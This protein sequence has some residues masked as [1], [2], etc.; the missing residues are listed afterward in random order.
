MNVEAR[1]LGAALLAAGLLGC[2]AAGPPRMAP[3]PPLTADEQLRVVPMMEVEDRR[4]VGL[5]AALEAAAAASPA[6]RARAAL[7]VGRLRAADGR[8]VLLRLL[9]DPDTAVAATAAFALG[10]LGDSATAPHLAHALESAGPA[11]RTVAAEAAYALGKVRSADA[12]SALESF[13]RSGDPAAPG[14][15]EPV[16]SALLATWR[17]PRPADV[18]FIIRWTGA[19]DPGLRWRAAYALVRR[20]TPAAA[21]HMQ[22]LASDPDPRV[23]AMA[24]RGVTRAMADSAGI[25]TAALPLIVAAVNDADYAVRVNAVRTLGTYPQSQSVEL[26][27]ALVAGEDRHLAVTA[28]ESLGRLGAAAAAS[29][30]ALAA[31]VADASRPVFVRQTALESLARIAPARA[32]EVATRHAA[33]GEWR[34]RVGAA[35]A[36]A[37]TGG[38]DRAGA[39]ARDPDG[40]VAAAALTALV[41]AAGESLAPLRPLLIEALSS[42]DI[43]VRTA[44]IGALGRMADPADLPLLLDAYDRALR[45]DDNDAQLAAID[46]LARLQRPG[47]APGRAFFARFPRPADPLVRLRASERFPEAGAPWGDPLPIDPRPVPYA[48]LLALAHTPAGGQTLLIETDQGTI[49]LRMA[50]A[51]APL[52]VHNFVELARAGYFDGQ[53]WPRVVP[54]FVVQ[55]GDPRGDTS[56]GPGY[57]IRDEFNRLRY[58]TGTL[59]MAL[60]GP[61]TGGSQWFI[62]HSPQ[63]HLDGVYTVFGRVVAGQEVT[64]RILP[65]DRI[66]RIHVIP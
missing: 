38:G 65:G 1:S 33:D 45:D 57:S 28:G 8:D 63:P 12:A 43:G 25:G 66:H 13:L 2:A 50:N 53:E 9:Q 19:A 58:G 29:A 39:L 23:R 15:P 64:E 14:D 56:G 61:D 5:Q 3:P 26:L 62:T 34:V 51:D 11:R 4:E 21:P 6:V 17:H 55:G 46:A 36:L 35:R 54:N 27:I 16:A 37:V 7:S 30:D 10:Q 31:A 49:E 44:A 24:M 48:E 32:T 47:G 20:P 60:S 22:Q 52:T 59:G 18:D 40:R 41:D 42:A